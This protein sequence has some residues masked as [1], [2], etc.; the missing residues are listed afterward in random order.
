M[1]F[2]DEIDVTLKPINKKHGNSIR[3][4]SS[5]QLDLTLIH[6]CVK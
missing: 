1:Y 5:T 6:T 2:N 3:C 4:Q